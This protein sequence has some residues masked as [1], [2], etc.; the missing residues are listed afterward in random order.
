MREIAVNSGVEEV[1]VECYA[2]YK[3]EETPRAVVLEGKRFEVVKVLSR[4]RAFD[5]DNGQVRDTWRCR[6]EDGRAVA[7]ERL[8]GGIWRVSPAT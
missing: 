1:R 6:L 5:R 4:K 7:I 2:G 8:E 3:G